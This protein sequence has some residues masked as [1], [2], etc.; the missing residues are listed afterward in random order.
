MTGRSEWPEASTRPSRKRKWLR[1][2]LI[3]LVFLLLAGSTTAAGARTWQDNSNDLPGENFPYDSAPWD[4]PEIPR[5]AML[6]G[7]SLV[8]QSSA[9]AMALGASRAH[10]IK[11]K[12]LSG[13]APC[14]FFDSYGR[15]A[16]AFNPSQ[17]VIS[18]V[19][20]ATTACMVQAQGFIPPGVLSQA[21][22]DKIVAVYYWHTRALV[23]W[24]VAM[25]IRTWLEAPPIMAPGTWHGQVNAGIVAVYKRLAVENP[26][27][28][29]DQTG[30]MLLSNNG[31][32]TWKDAAGH[33]LRYKDGTHLMGTYGTTAHAEGMLAGIVT[34]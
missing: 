20:N 31:Q 34:P 26:E 33:P 18:Y 15:D 13:G 19:G 9:V 29:Y 22:I 24:N 23:E 21:Q 4:P 3:G 14:D 16:V 8:G 28:F 1:W 17:V 10:E 6:V 27:T 7:D 30:R 5:R 32:F 12:A 11:V 25:G 2:L